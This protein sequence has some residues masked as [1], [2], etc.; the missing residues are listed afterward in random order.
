MAYC[1]LS[2]VTYTA[3]GL[4]EFNVGCG[5]GFEIPIATAA[6]LESGKEFTREEGIPVSEKTRVFLLIRESSM[7]G[8]E[9]ESV[10]IP[11][12]PEKGRDF[13]FDPETV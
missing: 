11:P 7:I 13:C 12:P 9:N 8:S 10:R 6:D 1:A 4:Y 2:P 5:F 3:E